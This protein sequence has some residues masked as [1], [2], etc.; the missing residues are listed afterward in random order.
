MCFKLPASPGL[1]AQCPDKTIFPSGGQLIS[2]DGESECF[3]QVGEYCN[4]FC[5]SGDYIP[6]YCDESFMWN[7]TDPCFGKF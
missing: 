3:Q 6:V 4:V 1:I 5:P 2:V 7:N